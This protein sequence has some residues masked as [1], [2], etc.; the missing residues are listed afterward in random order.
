V[1][2]IRLVYQNFT[3][4]L[5]NPNDFLKSPKRAHFKRKWAKIVQ[6]EKIGSNGAK[7]VSA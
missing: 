5:P 4:E 7:R 6:C 3:L 2:G 1:F